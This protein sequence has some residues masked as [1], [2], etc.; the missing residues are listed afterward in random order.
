M[1]PIKLQKIDESLLSEHSCLI[2]SDH[3]Y[4]IGEYSARQGFDHINPNQHI[5]NMNQVINN[6]KKPMERKGLNEWYYKDQAIL[7]IAFWLMSTTAWDKLKTATWI[8]IPPSK[9]SSD[10]QY[11]DRLWRVLLKMKEKDSSLDIRELIL[12]KSNRKAAHEPGASRPKVTEHQKNFVIDESKTNPKPKA[13]ILFDDIITSGAHFKA[14]QSLLQ[15]EFPGIPIIGIFV[16]RS[17]SPA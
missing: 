14:A 1:D 9:V 5:Q 15:V 11:D 3:C 4:F 12:T 16:A 6:F 13:I 8:P 7:K 17:V 10:P 2:D